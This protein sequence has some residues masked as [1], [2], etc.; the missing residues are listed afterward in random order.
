MSGEFVA[1]KVINKVNKTLKFLYQKQ[2]MSLTPLI[3][4]IRWSALFQPYHDHACSA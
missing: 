4:E 2:N 1:L 3:R